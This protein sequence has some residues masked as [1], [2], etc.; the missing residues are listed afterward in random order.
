MRLTV[1]LLIA[2]TALAW[3]QPAEIDPADETLLLRQP[4]MSATHVAFTYGNEL[5]VASRQGGVARQLTSQL[6]VEFKPSFSP[7]GEQIAFSANYGGNTDVYVVSVEGGSARRLTY[8]PYP[9]VVCGW[10][11]DGKRVLFRS[12]RASLAPTDRLFLARVDGVGTPQALAIPK[13]YHASYNADA[14]RIAYTPTRDAFRSWKRYRGGR[15]PPVWIYD[16]E[17]HEV[18]QI[19]HENATDTFP[20]WLGGKVYFASDRSKDGRMNLYSYTPGSKQA[21][22]QLTELADFDVRNMSAGPDALIV[23]TGGA[24]H[25]FDPKKGEL[26][27]IRI[28]VPS[29]G[30]DRRKRWQSVGGAARW[31]V[32]APN[33]KRV[34][35]EARGEIVTMPRNHGAVRNLSQSPGAHDRSPLWS[36]DGHRLAWL[37]DASGEYRLHLRDRLARQ[38]ARQLDLGP[39]GFFYLEGWSPDGEKILFSAKSGRL[40]YITLKTGQITE[41]D[42]ITGALGVVTA[43]TDWS[44]DSRWI[45]YTRRHPRTLHDHLVLYELASGEKHEITDHFAHATYPAWSKDGKFLFFV[46]TLGTG[47][48]KFGLDMRAGTVNYPSGNIYCV[49]LSKSTPHPMPTRSDEAVSAPSKAAPKKAA[50]LV[51]LDGID[52]RILAL[53]IPAGQHY[54]LETAKDKLLYLTRPRAGQTTLYRFDFASRSQTAVRSDVGGFTIAKDGLNMLVVGRGRW[55]VCS[56]T[57]SGY[58]ELPVSRVQVEVDPSKE[59]PQI[60]REVWRI[61]R[62]FFYDKNLH[63]VDWDAMWT[64]WSAF[65]P[66]VRHRSDLN[67]VIAEMIGELACG[68]QYVSGGEYSSPAREPGTGLLGADYKVEAGRYKIKRIYRGRNWE[69]RTRAPLTEPGVDAKVGDFLIAI[70]G[71]QLKATDNLYAAFR[72]TVGQ[73][74]ELTLSANADGS[75]PRRTTVVPLGDE[76]SLRRQ[77]WIEGN[78]ARVTKLSDGKL[79]YTYL[80]N[81][82]G[83]GRAAFD[84]DF[85]SQIDKAGFVIDE[86]YNGGGKVADYIIDVLNRKPMCYW[87]TRHG[88]L[89]RTPFGTMTGPK[90]M[91]INESAGSGGDA[92]PWLFRR[93]GLG[94]LVGTRTWGGLVGISGYPVLMDGGRVTSASFGVMDTEGNWAVE[95]VGVAPDH[96]VIEWPKEVIAGR[97]PQLEKAVELALK[98]LESAPKEELPVY[99]PPS[100]R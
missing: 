44:P 76:G 46:A 35:F 73:P 68:H 42:Q 7:D 93:H 1:A 32:M 14:S 17:T 43:T 22:T 38:P 55:G 28:R 85:Y 27:R 37:S 62:D 15:V 3:G 89:G 48:R 91:V 40:A 41:V 98:A 24:L 57:G 97:D 49:V 45:V 61:Q 66:H 79:G 21:P 6:G 92:L 51:D 31:G 84:R 5:W 64:R 33:G 2:S 8:H 25:I 29:D 9:D 59:W 19:P 13:V 50:G 53:P 63:G 94:Q 83:A 54:G 56:V 52:Q 96:E 65:L 69:A 4:T 71:R 11:P 77:A 78:R 70:N 72:A 30:L 95:N 99:K 90:V 86:R 74:I 82:A 36:P 75:K 58:K 87:M 39:G 18:E 60:L 47:P 16:P 34:A 88:W 100:K 67:V 12:R 10:H 26:E 20:C 81:T 23:A 80:P